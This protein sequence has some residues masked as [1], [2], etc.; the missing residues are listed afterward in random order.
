MKLLFHKYDEDKDG[1]LTLPELD[2][3]VREVHK[4]DVEH[5]VMISY[6]CTHTHTHTHTLSLSLSPCLTTK[7]FFIPPPPTPPRTTLISTSLICTKMCSLRG[8]KGRRGRLCEPNWK[9]SGCKRPSSSQCTPWGSWTRIR[10]TNCQKKS[11][12]CTSTPRVLLYRYAEMQADCASGV[13]YCEG[14]Y[15]TGMRRCKPIV[16]VGYSTAMQAECACGVQCCV[17]S[18]ADAGAIDVGP[19]V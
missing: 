1:F 6:P 5:K 12:R 10:T 7:S 17:G 15:C 16:Q 9:M 8:P 14:Y 11:G 3:L 13:Q 2:E 18:S 4:E 19:R